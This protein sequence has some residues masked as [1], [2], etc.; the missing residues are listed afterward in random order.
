MNELIEKIFDLEISD[1]EKKVLIQKVVNASHGLNRNLSDG[2]YLKAIQNPETLDIDI[3]L[4]Y[5][6]ATETG[7]TMNGPTNLDKDGI[8]ELMCNTCLKDIQVG[9]KKM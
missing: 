1:M 3:Q 2:C 9:G 7:M 5:R 8:I 4:W 6:N